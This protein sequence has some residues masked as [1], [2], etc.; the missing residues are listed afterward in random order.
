M[1]NFSL[2][3]KREIKPYLFNNNDLA[4][5][6]YA[7]NGSIGKENVRFNGLVTAPIVMRNKVS[8]EDCRQLQNALVE[9]A[10]EKG[11]SINAPEGYKRSMTAWVPDELAFDWLFNYVAE[12][13]NDANQYY[14]FDLVGM[15]DAPQYCKYSVGDKFDWHLDNS[16]SQSTLRKISISIQ[17]TDGCEYEGGDIEFCPHGIL[18]DARG[19]GTVIAF[20]A[21]LAHRVTTITSG[22]RESLIAWAY[23]S[24][25]R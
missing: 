16:E 1:E 6:E 25:F 19:I 9:L 18:D 14:M 8:S 10:L 17:L 2:K 4:A 13:L 24:A 7:S 11:K 3:L 20:P 23:G 22:K 12:L 21:Y 5:T 15:V